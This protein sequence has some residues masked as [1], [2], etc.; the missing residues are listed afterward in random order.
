MI[1]LSRHKETE[2]SK[3]RFDS[4]ASQFCVDYLQGWDLFSFYSSFVL[5]LAFPSK[6]EVD[7]VGAGWFVWAVA[8]KIL[9]Q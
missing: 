3:Q 7:A 6:L 1:I 8:E 5:S 4:V 9:D 2:T